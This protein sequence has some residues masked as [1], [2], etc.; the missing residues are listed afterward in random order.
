MIRSGSSPDY[1]R[2]RVTEHLVRFTELYERLMGGCID[3][4]R[5]QAISARD[6]IF[7]KLNYRYWSGS[8]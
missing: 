3:E 6:N 4:Q 2:S 8:K 1:A 5:L 7:P